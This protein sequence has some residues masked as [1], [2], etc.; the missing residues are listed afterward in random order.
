MPGN[1]RELIKNLRLK[2]ELLQMTSFRCLLVLAWCLAVAPAQ[3]EETFPQP[4]E[5]QPDVD[6]WVS[7]FTN[8]STDEG[9][10]H[11][12]RNLAVVYDR[13]DMPATLSRRERNRRVDAR[14]KELQA[15]LRSLASGKRDNLS[16]KRPE[17]WRCGP[18]ACQRAPCVPLSDAFASSTGCA[19]ASRTG[20]NVRGAGATTSMSNSQRWVCQSILRRCRMSSLRTT[21]MPDRMSAHRASGNSHAAPGAASC[22]S[23][24]SSTSATILLLPRRQLVDYSPTTIR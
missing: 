19:T 3:A 5:L 17:C 1:F 23:T 18:T 20:S 10:L 24:M 7:I 21:R 4:P 2:P 9:V 15:V 13:L 11:D 22:V 14:R 8:Y 12:N 6:F 16:T